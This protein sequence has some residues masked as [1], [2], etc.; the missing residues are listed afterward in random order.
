LEEKFSVA[1][2]YHCIG[3]AADIQV[4][5]INL[6]ELLIYTEEVDFNGIGFY[7]K[8]NFLHLDALA[9]I[10]KVSKRCLAPLGNF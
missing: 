1:S 6:I 4:K 5:D 7:K 2:S 8:K 10:R 9:G 3:L